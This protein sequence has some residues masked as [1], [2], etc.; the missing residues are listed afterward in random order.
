MFLIISTTRIILTAISTILH[1]PQNMDSNF[2][3]DSHMSLV[4][5]SVNTQLIAAFGEGN[6]TMNF[7]FLL[8]PQVEKT[9][10]PP[11]CVTTNFYIPIGY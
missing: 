5:L 8:S 11:V 7:V 3:L 2:F 4:V 10:I 6:P 9:E 1:F